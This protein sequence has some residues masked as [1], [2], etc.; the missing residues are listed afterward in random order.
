MSQVILNGFDI[1]STANRGNSVGVAQIVETGVRAA[2]GSCGPFEVAVDDGIGQMV[3]EPIGEDQIVILP[4]CAHI[5]ALL[6]LG[7]FVCF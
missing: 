3:A 1:I 4:C 7:C 2:D 6:F 5:Q